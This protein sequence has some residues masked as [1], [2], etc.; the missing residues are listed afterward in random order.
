[1]TAVSTKPDAWFRRFRPAS[2]GAVRLFCL[3]HAGGSAPYFMPLARALAGEYDVV[4]VQYPGRQDR[5]Q[6]PAVEDIGTL[7]DLFLETFRA[8]PGTPP[9]LFGHSMGAVVA[10]ELARRLE[11]EGTPPLGLIASGR[12]A[13]HL[14]REE[15]VHQ[16]D[17][18]GL[19]AEIQQLNGTDPGVL[20]DEELLRM[21]LPSLR[22]DYRAVETY[23]HQPGEPL[24][25]P[26]SV[27]IGESD[28]RVTL[29]EARAW[30]ELTGGAFAFRSFPGGHFYLN[31]QQAA[32]TR[33]IVE[34]IA[35]FREAPT[36]TAP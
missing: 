22:A 11:R 12:R 35:A 2:P 7:A 20:N 9:V 13:P 28:P 32:V 14:H 5:R 18:N 34:S 3:P 6:E 23:R 33:A 36:P 15:T 1:M 26:V 24:R 10:Y 16:R 30:R 4:C 17:D 29:D 25:T 31:G 19:V 8:E 27:L 21:I